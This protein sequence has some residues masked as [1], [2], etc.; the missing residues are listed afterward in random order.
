MPFVQK[1][2]KAAIAG[3]CSSF[4]VAENRTDNQGLLSRAG[5]LVGSELPTGS[6]NRCAGPRK[7]RN[8][9]EEAS[10]YEESVCQAQYHG[11]G[12]ASICHEVCL[13]RSDSQLIVAHPGVGTARS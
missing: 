6:D 5:F 1:A 7:H 8:V 11:V 13:Q 12:A 3:L 9:R 4:Y 10:C 2:A